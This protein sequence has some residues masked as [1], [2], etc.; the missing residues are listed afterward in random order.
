MLCA[1]S[2]ARAAA[3][4]GVTEKMTELELGSGKKRR[5][6]EHGWDEMG[7]IEAS[8]ARDPCGT[9]NTGRW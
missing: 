6:A 2:C 5:R 4:A 8:P 7:W 9:G 3:A 1:S